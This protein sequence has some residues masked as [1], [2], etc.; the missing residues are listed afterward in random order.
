MA[1]ADTEAP[2][3]D[4]SSLHKHTEEVRSWIIWNDQGEVRSDMTLGEA[5]RFVQGNKQDDPGIYA[6]CSECAETIES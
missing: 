2:I 1:T 5:Q 6:E 3:G 4:Q